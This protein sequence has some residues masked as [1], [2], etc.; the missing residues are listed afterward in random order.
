[1][2]DFFERRFE[3]HQTTKVVELFK[4]YEMGSFASILDRSMWDVARLEKSIKSHE[5]LGEFF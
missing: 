3:I 4:K 1:M 2:F 5:P